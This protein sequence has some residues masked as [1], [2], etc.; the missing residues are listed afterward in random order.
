M[1]ERSPS[2]EWRWLSMFS[3]EPGQLFLG[4]VIELH[5]LAL[6]D[7]HSTRIKSATFHVTQDLVVTKYENIRA[8]GSNFR[9]L[10]DFSMLVPFFK[11]KSER[12]FPRFCIYPGDTIFFRPAP[13]G[14]ALFIT[15]YQVEPSGDTSTKNTAGYHANSDRDPV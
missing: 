9:R 3:P 4:A 1:C 12:E 2:L 15:V 11:R 8:G 7:G 5:G 10:C 6:Y 14:F 13:I